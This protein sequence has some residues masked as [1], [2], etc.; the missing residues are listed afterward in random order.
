MIPGHGVEVIIMPHGGRDTEVGFA[1][2]SVRNVKLIT[3][4]LMKLDGRL[5]KLVKRK[6]GCSNSRLPRQG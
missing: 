4:H 2:P 1:F 5:I 3:M 6:F